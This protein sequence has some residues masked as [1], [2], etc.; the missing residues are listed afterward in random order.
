MHLT[1]ALDYIRKAL[2]YR[3]P[4]GSPNIL[5][6]EHRVEVDLEHRR[7]IQMQSR[8]KDF[9]AEAFHAGGLSQMELENAVD[10]YAMQVLDDFKQ[11]GEVGGM[12][13]DF[14]IV[15]EGLP[16]LPPPAQVSRAMWL[17]QILNETPNGTPVRIADRPRGDE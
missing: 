1:E 15:D 3:L 5:G 4:P 11:K 10:D 8:F 13:P 7:G 16:D 2:A 12:R 6:W 14:G 17:A 9:Y